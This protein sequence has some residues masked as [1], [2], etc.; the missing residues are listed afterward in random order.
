M[1]DSIVVDVDL[2]PKAVVDKTKKHKASGSVLIPLVWEDKLCNPKKSL[3]LS[4]LKS[5][6]G[7]KAVCAY[8]KVSQEFEVI[9]TQQNLYKHTKLFT[10]FMALIENNYI[11][12]YCIRENWNDCGGKAERDILR[13]K[14]DA[15]HKLYIL[16]DCDIN[17]DLYITKW[18]DMKEHICSAKHQQ[19]VVRFTEPVVPKLTLK[20]PAVVETQPKKLKLVSYKTLSFTQ[21]IET[22]ALNDEQFKQE[23]VKDYQQF[24]RNQQRAVW[25]KAFNIDK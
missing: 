24:L 9:H 11:N 14:V 3:S 17:C 1:T 2:A 10:H 22:I 19:Y 15:E 20:V 21:E 16:C 13:Y 6:D 8:C 18:E 7:W 5:N 4:R 25:E 12:D 23:M